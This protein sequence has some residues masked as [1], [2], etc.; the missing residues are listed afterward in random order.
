MKVLLVGGSEVSEDL[1]KKVSL[2]HD[3]IIALDRGYEHLRRW[4]LPCNEVIGDYDSI[5]EVPSFAKA[6][7]KKEKDFTD[8]EAGIEEAIGHGATSITVVACT[9]GRLDHFLNGVMLLFRYDLPIEIIDESNVIYA[10]KNSF[11]LVPRGFQFFSLIPLRETTITIEGA[12]YNLKDRFVEP[13]S[14]LLVSNET[15]K[16]AQ[17]RFKDTPMIVVLSKDRK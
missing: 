7:F 11:T 4:N 13:F 1:L 10:K 3:Y 14:S 6:P 8:L 16:E 5:D 9:G 15:E 17:I 2:E 12:K